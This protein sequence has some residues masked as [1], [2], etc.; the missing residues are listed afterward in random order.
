M[1]RV[2]W[3]EEKKR[4]ND[5]TTTRSGRSVNEGAEERQM[6]KERETRREKRKGGRKTDKVGG[7]NDRRARERRK[8]SAGLG[9]HAGVDRASA[10]QAR[11]V[12]PAGPPLNTFSI[13]SP[14]PSCSLSSSFILSF[15]RTFFAFCFDHVFLQAS[16]S[17]TRHNLSSF[18]SSFL[19]SLPSNFFHVRSYCP[20]GR[21][22][23]RSSSLRVS[24]GSLRFPTF[25]LKRVTRLQFSR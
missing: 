17:R 15:L 9:G 21:R 8:S 12:R 6:E 19:T 23:N 2:G 22:S 3:K 24:I 14:F 4:R 16:R 13:F 10:A 1:E 18:S 7:S 20:A 5:E 11:T 25:D